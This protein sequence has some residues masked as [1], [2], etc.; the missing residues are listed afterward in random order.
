MS[1]FEDRDK[2]MCRVASPKTSTDWP[3]NVKLFLRG[4]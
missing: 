4:P 2:K 3:V 1:G